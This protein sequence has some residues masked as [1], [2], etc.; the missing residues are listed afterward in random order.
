MVIKSK[1]DINAAT[2]LQKYALRK[3]NNIFY[4]LCI[5]LIILVIINI[6]SA[7]KNFSLFLLVSVIVFATLPSTLSIIA[8]RAIKSN[9]FIGDDIE[10]E[11]TFGE[12]TLTVRTTRSNAE[13]GNSVL[14]KKDI[15]KITEHKNYLFLFLTSRQAFIIDKTNLTEAEVENI[16]RFK[17]K[18]GQKGE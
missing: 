15:S 4:A 8:R 5:P 7:G 6:V 11:F 13:F 3:F 1:N 2:A 10:N 12:D 18:N 9:R 17:G 14:N 16:R